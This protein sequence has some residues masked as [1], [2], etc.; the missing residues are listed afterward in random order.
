[1]GVHRNT[2]RQWIKRGLPTCDDQRPALILGRDLRAFLEAQRRSRKRPCRPGE[3][4]CCRCREPRRPLGGFVE[5][6]AD[7]ATLGTLVGMCGE[8]EAM[9]YRRVNPAR[10]AEVCGDLEVLPTE[11][12]KRIADRE[13]PSVNSDFKTGEANHAKAQPE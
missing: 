6:Q 12:S 3:I 13:E 8:C 10:L 11:A 7:T 1:M 2:V 9:L 4:Y 5:Y